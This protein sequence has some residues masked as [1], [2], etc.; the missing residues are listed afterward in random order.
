MS[1]DLHERR[2]VGELH[3]VDGREVVHGL[4]RRGLLLADLGLVVLV[5]GRRRPRVEGRR[6]FG[7]VPALRLVRVALVLRRIQI[8]HKLL[9]IALVEGVENPHFLCFISRS[10]R[11][12]YSFHVQ[13]FGFIV[14]SGH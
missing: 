12:L 10:G 13:K 8:L 4:G 6:S 3:I 7:S 14:L 2:V 9:L 11:R 1:E 5:S